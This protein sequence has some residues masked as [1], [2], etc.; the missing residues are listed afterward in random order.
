MITKKQKITT[1]KEDNIY[2]VADD[3]Y[4]EEQLDWQLINRNA[5]FNAKYD[6]DKKPIPFVAEDQDFNKKL[7][8]NFFDANIRP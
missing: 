1:E 5:Q 4:T 6:H 2:G 8:N 3:I 7:K